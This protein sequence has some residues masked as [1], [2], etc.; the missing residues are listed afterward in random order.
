M[1][2]F[3]DMNLADNT[4]LRSTIFNAVTATVTGENTV[5]I[6]GATY[7]LNGEGLFPFDRYTQK[8]LEESGVAV[9]EDFD[10]MDFWT[11]EG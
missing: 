7:G 5:F 2:S 9:P 1:K 8:M 10:V 3:K 6:C 11:V 4:V